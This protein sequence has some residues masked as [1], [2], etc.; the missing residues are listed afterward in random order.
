MNDAWTQLGSDI[1][2]TAS[3]KAGTSVSLSANGTHV[4]IGGPEYSEVGFTNR[5]R[6]Q[7]WKYTVSPPGWQQVG[8]N[9]DGSGAGD[10]SG[11]VVSLSNPVTEYVVAIGSPGHQSSRGHVRAF[12]FTGGAWTQRGVDLDGTA[13]GDEFGASIDLSKNGS[14]LIAGAPKKRRWWVECRARTRLFL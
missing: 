8:L 3:S 6:V 5:G 10:F 4:A 1:I 9:I 12:V 14:Y 11:K 13:T 7:V 2:G